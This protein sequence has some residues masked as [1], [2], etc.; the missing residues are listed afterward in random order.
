MA[1]G[2]KLRKLEILLTNEKALYPFILHFG[3]FWAIEAAYFD[4]YWRFTNFN[5]S[6][7]NVSL[8]WYILSPIWLLVT[9]WGQLVI[10]VGY[11]KT[12]YP[13]ILH[14]G[15]F[16]GIE[17]AYFDQYWRFSNFDT[18]WCKFLI[19]LWYIFI[20]LFT[21]DKLM[22]IEDLGCISKRFISIHTSFW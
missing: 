12:L 15:G 11:A 9:N 1:T 5:T 3:G 19:N 18:P 20:Y 2:D 8:I 10:L 4:K 13:F 22:T 14:F 16:Y 17:E 7:A 6:W 21:G